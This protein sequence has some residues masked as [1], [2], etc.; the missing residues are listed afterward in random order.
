MQMHMYTGTDLSDRDQWGVS[1]HYKINW[2]VSEQLQ[3]V[4]NENLRYI[5][6]YSMVLYVHLFIHACVY[7]GHKPMNPGNC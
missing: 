5:R 4:L 3:D 6:I 1:S 2:Q 7:N